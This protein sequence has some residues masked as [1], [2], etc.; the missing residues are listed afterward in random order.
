MWGDAFFADLRTQYSSNRSPDGLR[1]SQPV[2]RI[3][4]HLVYCTHV[5]QIVYGFVH[6]CVCTR[7]R[8]S[9]FVHATT[10]DCFH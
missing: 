9:K 4:H 2:T 7:R 5:L 8:D 6:L 1:M 3:A 10:M